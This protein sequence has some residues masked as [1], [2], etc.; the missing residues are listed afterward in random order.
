MTKKAEIIRK[1]QISSIW[2][3][4]LVTILIG[5]WMFYQH[6]QQVGES[7][8]IVMPTAEGVTIG[9]TQIRVKSVKI[10]TI[11]NVKLGDDNSY[12]IAQA[13]IEQQYSHLLR[14]DSQIWTV[15][16][17]IE[18]SG[19]SGINTLLSGIYFEFQPGNAEEFS[20]SYL[21]RDTPPLVGKHIQGGRYNLVSDT[22]EVLDVGAP[23]VFK[24]FNVGQVETADFDWK[25]QLMTYQVFIRAP[26]QNLVTENSAFWVSSGIDF[27]LSAEGVVVRSK[28]ISN[29]FRGGISFAVPVGKPAGKFVEDGRQYTLHANYDESLE[30]QFNQVQQYV[31][32]FDQSIRGLK[33]GAPVEYKG[34]RIG[35]VIQSPATVISSS[36]PLSFGHDKE[37]VPVLVQVEFGRMHENEE[38]AK[39]YWQQNID[40]WVKNGLRA[41]LKPGNLL[42][43]S[44]YVDFDLFDESEQI[45][46]ATDNYQVFPSTFSGFNLIANQVSAVLEKFNQLDVE[47]SVTTLN[48]TLNSFQLLAEDLQ[49][50][51]KNN[52]TQSIPLNI[53]QTLQQLQKTLA[54][55]EKGAP[56]YHDL[57]KT[58]QSIEKIT[59]DL[60]PFSKNLNEHPNILIF[61]KNLKPD[62]QPKKNNN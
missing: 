28:S 43:G 49:N 57:Q 40:Q 22:A 11:T 27:K 31:I 39:D 53:N 36:T 20:Y 52:H 61:D 45:I 16:P 18:A 1:R 9:K 7:I 58:L 62:V 21:L 41:T 46:L 37:T 4:P 6:L 42:T 60:E 33:A 3:L 32:N 54:D 30:K 34:I 14:K 38:T 25:K 19:I 17:R 55:F 47:S 26:Y 10:G 56:L 51:V 35:T 8:Y 2:L 23:V 44:L 13:Q 5:F 15:K 24:G 12:V 29:I 59:R 48:K 50:L